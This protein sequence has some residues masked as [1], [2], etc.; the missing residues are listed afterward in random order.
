MHRAAQPILTAHQRADAKAA[1]QEGAISHKDAIESGLSDDQ[2]LT[3]IRSRRWRRAVTGVY[4]VAGAPDTARQ[5]AMVAYLASAARG[6]VVSH[7]SAAAEWGLW[8]HPP[9]PHV[10]VPAGRSTRCGAAVVHRSSI[11]VVDRA[12]RKAM[13]VTSVSR[14]LVD[15][16]SLVERPILEGLVDDAL[17]RQLA[18]PR[19]VDAALE[20]VGSGRRG[21]AQLRAVLEAWS[22][23]IVPGSPAEVR[24]LRMCQDLGID[25]L[26]PQVEVRD[27]L[28]AFVARL[29]L[30]DPVR[31]RGFEY[32][33]V[34]YHGP[35]AWQRDEARY[36]RLRALGWDVEPVDKHDLCPGAERLRRIA[37]RWRAV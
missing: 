18:S 8:P 26:Q 27:G 4:V 2:I 36:A 12:H 13:A 17:C 23:G 14:T 3:L 6:G 11:P 5:R 9:L 20:R 19:S 33:G 29:D 15:V 22:P 31:K 30:G 34:R 24:L 10:T 21:K 7:L 35:R 25:G 1:L 28:G 37:D 32:D 16:A